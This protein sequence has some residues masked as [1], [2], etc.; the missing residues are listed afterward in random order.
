[1]K[2][3]DELLFGSRIEVAQSPLLDGPP[4][5]FKPR[6]S[7]PIQRSQRRYVWHRLFELLPEMAQNRRRHVVQRSQCLA[8]HADEAKLQGGTD[9]VPRSECL[10]NGTPVPIIER[11]PSSQQEI[12]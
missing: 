11:E 7:A 2:M 1:M 8:S 4:L 12:G 3:F 9:P 10:A 6:L 5:M